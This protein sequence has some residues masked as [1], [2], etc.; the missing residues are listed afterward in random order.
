MYINAKNNQNIGLTVNPSILNTPIPDFEKRRWKIVEYEKKII[1]KYKNFLKK[2]IKELPIKYELPHGFFKLFEVSYFNDD[3]EE[4]HT[5]SIV[6]DNETEVKKTN[7]KLCE[8]YFKFEK[9]LSNINNTLSIY[10]KIL[11]QLVQDKYKHNFGYLSGEFKN[12][13]NLIIN[14]RS[15]WWKVSQKYA[16]FGI[17]EIDLY[18]ENVFN[19]VYN[20]E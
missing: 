19:V 11:N 8:E 6:R 3:E 2:F 15:Y 5:V 13:L 4:T 10:D 7:D 18:P 9:K 1:D 16:H 20:T 17:L 12:R 14:S